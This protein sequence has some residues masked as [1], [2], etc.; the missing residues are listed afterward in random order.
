MKKLNVKPEGRDGIY[1][2]EKDEIKKWLNESSF[3]TIHN[4]PAGSNGMLIGADH[5][6]ESVI[7]DIDKSKQIAILIGSACSQNLGHSLAM[8]INN[9]LQM[10]D[11]GNI[12]KEDLII[13]LKNAKQQNTKNN[14]QDR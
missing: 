6:L 2:V 13:N 10:F 9:K 14:N 12:T 7:S 5:T 1:I 11:I 4:I 3:E 8:I